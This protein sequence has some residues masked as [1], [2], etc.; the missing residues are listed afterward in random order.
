MPPPPCQAILLWDSSR[1]RGIPCLQ[2]PSY[3]RRLKSGRWTHFCEDCTDW[4]GKAGL[5]APAAPFA[6]QHRTPPEIP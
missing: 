3:P 4:A 1:S 6:K 2:T 5:L